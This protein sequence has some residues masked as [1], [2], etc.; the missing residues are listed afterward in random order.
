MPVGSTTG[1]SDR[2]PLELE[3]DF[4][5]KGRANEARIREGSFSFYINITGLFYLD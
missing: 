3:N 2:C 4:T 1:K 5:L